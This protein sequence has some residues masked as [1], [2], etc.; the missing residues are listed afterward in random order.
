MVFLVRMKE[1]SAPVKPG[2]K[3]FSK[4]REYIDPFHVSRLTFAVLH[5]VSI[6]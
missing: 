2:S 5:M 1:L 4:D 3:I 6:G